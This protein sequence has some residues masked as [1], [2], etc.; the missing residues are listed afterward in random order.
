M[1]ECRKTQRHRTLKVG[2]VIFNNGGGVI[3]MVRNMSPAG[4]CIEVTNPDEIPD[5][6]TLVVESDNLLRRCH[7]GW[8]KQK[9][10]GLI[11]N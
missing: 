10:I 11:F 2:S 3:C 6:F 8:R 1:I 5:A 7:V 9:Q 4:A